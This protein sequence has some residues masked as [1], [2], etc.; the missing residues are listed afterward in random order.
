MKIQFNRENWNKYRP[1]D[2]WEKNCPFCD[3]ISEKEKI[4][5][6]WKWKFFHIRYNKYP[7]LWLEK[8]LLAIPNRHITES[9][10]LTQDEQTELI[11]VKKFMRDFFEWQDYFSFLRETNGW[12]SLNH[13]HY[14]FL[15]GKIFDTDIENMLR[16][17]WF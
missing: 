16:K 11:T 2:W 10:N 6:I 4:L 14:H 5:I 17:Q 13:M 8:H 15:P 1:K 7:Y 12:K 3:T 9:Y